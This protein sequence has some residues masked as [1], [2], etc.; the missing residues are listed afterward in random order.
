MYYLNLTRILTGLSLSPWDNAITN[1][2][3]HILKPSV[4]PQAYYMTREIGDNMTRHIHCIL[5]FNTKDRLI[6]FSD[7]IRLHRLK[8]YID[9]F[10]EVKE[11][12]VKYYLKYIR[13][14]YKADWA[15][16]KDYAYKNSASFNFD[17]LI[18]AS[19]VKSDKL[20]FIEEVI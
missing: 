12:E 3:K 13:K 18:A 1:L 15:L 2:T 14:N 6:E 9:E 19:E 11:S 16:Y 4:T 5:V 10:T 8:A 7:Y 20:D 17:D